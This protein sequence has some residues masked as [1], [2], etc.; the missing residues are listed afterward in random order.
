MAILNNTGL[1]KRREANGQG[2]LEGTVMLTIVVPLLLI[3]VAGLVNIFA[4]M[5]YSAKLNLICS[6]SLKWRNENLYWLGMRRNDVELG[7]A[8][9]SARNMACAMAANAGIVLHPNDV[10]FEPVT[11]EAN[12]QSFEGTQCL[13]RARNI[14]LPFA[15][16]AGF[17]LL[18][19]LK[20]S[21]SIAAVPVPPPVVVGF[22]TNMDWP[23]PNGRNACYYVPCYGAVHSS[24]NDP[25][26][27]KLGPIP[28]TS[29]PIPMPHPSVYQYPTFGVGNV[30]QLMLSNQGH[31]GIGER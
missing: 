13:V 9:D 7:K 17:P 27:A 19:E 24:T 16:S 11:L 6:E 28:G 4:V 31:V 3:F 18:S 22:D 5:T 14:R 1:S 21:A 8:T 23:N 25:S 29:Q 15:G 26:S 10:D 2:I 20:S 30:G 12:G